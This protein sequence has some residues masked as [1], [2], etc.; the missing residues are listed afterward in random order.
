MTPIIMPAAQAHA[1]RGWERARRAAMVEEIQSK[2]GM[3]SVDLLSFDDVRDMLGIDENGCDKGIQEIPLSHIR[4]SVGRY[5]DFSKTFLPRRDHM[6]E[7]WEKVSA[8][9]YSKG[10]PPI[11]VYQLGD[12]YFVLD[13]NHRVSIAIQNGADTIEARVIK[14]HSAVGLSAEA[15]FDEVLTKAEYIRFLEQT[16]FEEL[17]S[18]E[19]IIFS[20]P[21]SYREVQDQIEMCHVM[22]G[23]NASYEEAVE[24]WYE[25]VYL[26]AVALIHEQGLLEQFSDRTEA[27]LFIWVWR[28][29]REIIEHG[30]FSLSS[31]VERIT[32]PSLVRLAQELSERYDPIIG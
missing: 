17:Y 5:R 8:A 32:H 2:L 7:R 23:D 14:L 16:D 6:R 4:G 24:V 9:T 11:E 15:D 28:F 18:D 10:T 22:L 31:I 21:G 19:E 12:A 20:L 30:E 26:P 13:G 1:H 27:D 25:D 3:R 29:R